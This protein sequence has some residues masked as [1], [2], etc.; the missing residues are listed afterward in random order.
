MNAKPRV[1]IGLGGCMDV[2]VDALDFF[3]KMN[4]NPNERAIHHDIIHNEQELS[5]GFLSYFQHGAAGERYVQN[6]NLF[7]K[8]GMINICVCFLIQTIG[9]GRT[10]SVSL[11]ILTLRLVKTLHNHLQKLNPKSYKSIFW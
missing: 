2:F 3:E 1:A 4:L 6:K 8:V 11:T 10:Y 5:E 9:G 7:R